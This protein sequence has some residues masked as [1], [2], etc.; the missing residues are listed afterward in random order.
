VPTGSR[1]ENEALRPYVPRVLIEWVRSG[2]QSRVRELRGT[3]AFVDIAGFTKLTERLARQGKVGAEELNDLLDACFTRLLDLAS[4]DGAELVKWGG[5]AVLLLFEGEEHGPR[6]CRAAFEMRRALREMGRVRCSVG[7]VSLRMSV[8]I[9]SGTFQFCFVGGDHLELVIAGPGATHTVLMESTAS[10]GEILLSSATAS[11][12]ESRLVGRPKGDGFLLRGLPDIPHPPSLPPPDD[13]GLDLARCVP[14]GLREYLRGRSHEAE[15][16]HVAVAF[17]EFTCT[18]DLVERAGPDQV[19]VALDACIRTVQEEARRHAVTFFET[20]ISGN[21]VKV[22]LVAGAPSSSGNDEE[23]MLLALRSIMDRAGALPLRIGVNSGRVFSSDFGPPYRRSYSIRGDAVNLAARLMGRA[24][25]GQILVTNVVLTRSRTSFEAHELPP[26]NVKGKAHPVK[27]HSLGTAGRRRLAAHDASPLV[28]REQEMAVLLEALESAIGRRGRIVEL[29]GEPGM[30]KSRLVEELV[31]QVEGVTVLIA[32]GEMYE[33]SSPYQP[34]RGMLRELLGIRSQQDPVGATKRL[35]D[36]VEANAPHLLPWLPLLG[37]PMDIEIPLTPETA[38]LDENFRQQ[39]L[40]A[41]TE[42]L[43][44]WTLPTPT[45]FVFDDAHWMDDASASLIRRIA[46]RTTRLPWLV[47]LTR[48]EV[49]GGFTLSEED[50]A[51]TLSLK[52]LDPSDAAAL[53]EASTET[54]PIPRHELAALAERSGGNPLFLRE[55]AAVARSEGLED[56]VPDTVEVLMTA[57][58]DRLG[59]DDRALLRHAAV[60]GVTF[61]LSV[62]A[63]ML[64]RTDLHSDE[65]IWQRLADFVR[66]EETG[67]FRFRHALLR[68]AAYEGLPYR[69][70]R[71][72]HAAAGDAITRTSSGFA[73]EQADLLSVHF[74]NAHRYEDAWR[75][76]RIAADRARSKYALVEAGRLYRR[77][78]DAARNVAGIPAPEIADVHEARGDLLDRLGAYGEAADSYRAARGLVG[79]DPLAESKLYLKEAWI[80]E[81]LGRYRQGLRW[82]TRGRR[83]LEGVEGA[84]AGKQRA[85]LAAWYAAIR[86]G[87]G[88]YLEVLAWCRRAIEEAE[89]SGEREALAQAYFIMDWALVDLGELEQATN[90]QRALKIYRELG[91]LGSAATVL[92]NMGMF[93]YF[94]GRW[95]EAIELYQQGHD[96]RLKIGDTVD[97]AMGPMNIGEILS[98]QGRLEEAEAMFRDVLRVWTAAGRKE[99]IALTTSNLA[100][101]ASRSGGCSKAMDLFDD[102]LRMFEEIGDDGEVL[103]TEAR[104]A[105]CLMLQGAVTRALAACDASLKRARAIGGVPLQ[106]PLLNRVKGWSLMQ[107]GRL[108][109]AGRAF[110][111]SL[112]AARSRQADFE[113]ALSLHAKAALARSTGTRDEDA[114]RE[115]HSL[116]ERLGVVRVPGIPVIP[117]ALDALDAASARGG[118]ERLLDP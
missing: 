59:A 64:G 91:N 93:A 116:F 105:E 26:F 31:S 23:G 100:R 11:L 36:R 35:R 69:R 76:A 92:N 70:R 112:E 65:S 113:I 21:G 102:A 117:G 99:F 77:A 79:G 49:D 32:R 33:A 56:V 84:E 95:N 51:V 66:E 96:L 41:V 104:I 30:G 19:A 44:E 1:H 110:E 87:Q 103:E 5:D 63:D 24:A 58:I 46:T 38:Q 39:Q 3:L 82:V 15:H 101:V 53:L 28:G 94:R 83:A 118:A 27:A 40:E 57:E 8:G 25:E 90:S 2:D 20:D 45:V 42:E 107:A 22:L 98:D 109:D 14:L 55:L 10:A 89:A 34:F 88:R 47:L 17:L 111:E 67:T 60:L 13:A 37:I 52:P 115:S 48:R 7:Y 72:L 81:R 75:Y 16:R 43:L 106:L 4:R 73:D 71:E 78:L 29:V 86:Q 18:D 12:L 9:H 62:L 85:R 50:G 108:E 80:S 68:D 61:P 114:E 97:A 74:F 6:A 54:F